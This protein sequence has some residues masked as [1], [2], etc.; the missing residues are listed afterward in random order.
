MNNDDLINLN[1][2]EN[3]VMSGLKDFQRDTVKRI[4]ELYEQGQNRILVSD[5]VGLGK[6]LIAKGV[7]AKFIKLRKK[8]NDDLVKVVYICS[9]AAIA[10]QNLDKLSIGGIVPE[11]SHTSRLSMQ[12]LNIFKAEYNENKIGVESAEEDGIVTKDYIQL[13]P[14]SPQTSFKITN[15]QGLAE[16]RALM[17]TILKRQD[18]L[19]GY[20][21]E[22]SEFLRFD[23]GNWDSLTDV[24]EDKVNKCDEKSGKKYLSYMKGKLTDI[25]E[26]HQFNDISYK[27]YKYSIT[28]YFL[29]YF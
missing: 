2:L 14:L 11:D 7:I 1:K 17:Y 10:Q 13:I 12:H 3:D 6:T 20:G 24:Y 26:K 19:E 29:Y 5:E 25:F 18:E 28:F 27:L 15:S 16:E 4:M 22:L 9:N 23:V 8:E 21:K